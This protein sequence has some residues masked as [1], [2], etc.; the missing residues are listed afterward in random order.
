MRLFLMISGISLL[1]SCVPMKQFQDL[2]VKNDELKEEMRQLSISSEANQVKAKE[3]QGNLNRA[4][5][6]IKQLIEDSVRLAGQLKTERERLN[7]LEQQQASLLAQLKKMGNS[8]ESADLMAYLQQLQDDI[9]KREDALR[10]SEAE[11]LKRKKELESARVAMIEQ[12]KRLLELQY[13]LDRK[14]SAMNA[15]KTAVANALTDFGSD[16]LKVHMKNGKVYVSLEEKLLFPSGSYEVN[17]M[18]ITALKKLAKVLEQ[19]PDIQIVVEGHTDNVP[20]R[21]NVILDN[22]DLSVKRATAVSRILLQNSTIDPSRITAAG[23]SEFVPVGSNDTAESRQKNR[24]TEIILSPEL[25]K[26]FKVLDTNNN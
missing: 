22:W 7:E 17:Q 19:K 18:G 21:G 8:E 2:Q 11:S 12:N 14:D 16:E 25:E 20:Y 9:Q 6:N 15:L 1:T 3:L 26:L 13:S 5:K 23:R 24:R 10:V 4:Q